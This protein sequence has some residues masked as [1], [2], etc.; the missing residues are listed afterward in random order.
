VLCSNSASGEELKEFDGRAYLSDFT[1]QA[2]SFPFISVP[3]AT[4][5]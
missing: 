3:E 2:E 1:L 5:N 4:V